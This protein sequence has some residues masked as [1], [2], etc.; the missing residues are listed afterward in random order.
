MIE[1]WKPV[2]N[3]EEKYSVSNLGNVKSLNFHRERREKIMKPQDTKDG[4]YHILLSKNGKQKWHLIHRLV[5]EAFNGPIPEGYFINHI[6]E[7][8]ADNRL[9]NLNLM[10]SKENC[11]WGT[12]NERMAAK[13]RSFPRSKNGG[14]S[15]KILQYDLDGVFIREWP[16]SA[17]INR[18]LGFGN[19]TTDVCR[20]ERK[21]AYGYIWKFKEQEG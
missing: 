7:T 10:T 20:G 11:N 8:K 13:L 18:Q 3:Y 4:Y 5:W 1:I 2:L 21:S 16:S 9:E 19:H 15:R 12:R 14:R 6:N 17:E